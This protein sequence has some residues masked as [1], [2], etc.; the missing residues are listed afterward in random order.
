MYAGRDIQEAC[1]S[2]RGRT[3]AAVSRVP[4]EIVAQRARV[5]PSAHLS[6]VMIV[7]CNVTGKY[8]VPPL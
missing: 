1:E 2:L 5:S 3:I 6:N 4:R 7:R 8:K